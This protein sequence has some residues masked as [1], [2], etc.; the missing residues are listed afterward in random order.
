LICI[1]DRPWQNPGVERSP[2]ETRNLWPVT[3]SAQHFG[4]GFWISDIHI[5]VTCGQRKW[6]TAGRE[7]MIVGKEMEGIF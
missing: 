3:Y 6:Q 2:L 7:I 1:G 4:V 5:S